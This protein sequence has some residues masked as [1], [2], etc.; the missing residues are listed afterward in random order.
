M[1]NSVLVNDTVRIKVK[2]IDINSS[3]GDQIEVSPESVYVS[4]ENASGT[5]LINTSAT[6]ISSYEYYYDYTPSNPGQYTVTFTR[7]S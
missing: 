6:S 5:Q 2:F 7:S 3:T 1:S 4:V